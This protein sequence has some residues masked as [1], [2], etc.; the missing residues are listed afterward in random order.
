MRPLENETCV[1]FIGLWGIA[2]SNGT[3]SLRISI[4]DR[5]NWRKG[6]GR[7]AMRLILNYAYNELN[8]HKVGFTVFEYNVGAIALYESLGFQRE[9][10]LRDYLHRDGT[11]YAM[12]YYGLLQ[13]EWKALNQ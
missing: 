5:K 12:Y 6:Y 4:G 11:R 3:T 13:P 2:W 1:G 9:A 8:L 10:S 7:D